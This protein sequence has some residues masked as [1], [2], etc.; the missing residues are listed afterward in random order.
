MDGKR[1]QK[2][3]LGNWLRLLFAE[4]RWSSRLGN[5]RAATGKT[6]G[7]HLQYL[8]KGTTILR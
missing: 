7:Q 2:G 6:S 4:R 3:V 8:N 5:L 1:S